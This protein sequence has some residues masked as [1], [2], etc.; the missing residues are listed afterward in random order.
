MSYKKWVYKYK[1][2]KTEEKEVYD[3]L[4]KEYIPLFNEDFI[5]VLDDKPPLPPPENPPKLEKD[6]KKEKP[7]E[8]QEHQVSKKGKNLYKKLSKIT[9]PDKGGDEKEFKYLNLLYQNED[10]L[11]MYIK[12][13]ELN[14]EIEEQDIENLEEVFHKNCALLEEKIDQHKSTAAWRWCTVDEKMKG[15]LA[16]AIEQQAPVK[17]RQK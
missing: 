11:G 6:Q 5:T 16:N 4:N 14:I 13:E 15:A 12:A 1:Y 10:I 3:K 17:R 9:H 2:L 8:I 7:D